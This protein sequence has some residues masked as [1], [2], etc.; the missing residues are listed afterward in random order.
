[1]MIFLQ[2]ISEVVRLRRLHR[3]VNRN[4]LLKIVFKI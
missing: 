4:P 1:M 2:H 3:T